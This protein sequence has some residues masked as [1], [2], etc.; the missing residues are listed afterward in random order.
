[1]H[2][3]QVLSAS[4]HLSFFLI[5][6]F[7][8]LDCR[9]RQQRSFAVRLPSFPIPLPLLSLYPGLQSEQSAVWKEQ[10]T[11]G[12]VHLSF[13]SCLAG[14]VTRR[15]R[16]QLSASRHKCVLRQNIQTCFFRPKLAINP[17]PLFPPPSL[18][19]VSPPS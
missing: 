16:L 10:E 13:K 18:P 4:P 6:A 3:A 12:G 11:Q 2:K 8:G 17:L 15:L 9:S 14:K 19:P 1:M 5:L 7:I